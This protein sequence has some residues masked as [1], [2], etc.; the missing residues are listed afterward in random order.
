MAWPAF[1]YGAR[2]LS[3]VHSWA[4]RNER[5]EGDREKKERAKNRHGKGWDQ[6]GRHVNRQWK[7]HKVG[8][9]GYVHWW[10]ELCSMHTTGVQKAKGIHALQL[11]QLAG[12][13][14]GSVRTLLTSVQR[15]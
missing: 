8:M 11:V 13:D 10:S 9:V 12:A 6:I 7:K 4:R 14:P 3:V 2:P 5:K 15:Q 1:R